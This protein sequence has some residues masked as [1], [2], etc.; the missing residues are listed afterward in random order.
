MHCDDLHVD[1]EPQWHAGCWG[2]SRR[3]H[4][5]AMYRDDSEVFETVCGLR[6]ELSWVRGDPVLSHN[7]IRSCGGLGRNP[8]G[9]VRCEGH[10]LWEQPARACEMR[11]LRIDSNSSGERRN[12]HGRVR[13]E[14]ADEDAL[15]SEPRRNLHGRVRCGYSFHRSLRAPFVEK[16]CLQREARLSGASSWFLLSAV[17]STICERYSSSVSGAHRSLGHC[18]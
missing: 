6:P 9:R 7:T 16:H 2:G 15:F 14:V 18:S 8:H 11:V 4:L 12:P 5:H 10:G 13:C 3:N 1:C 17:Q